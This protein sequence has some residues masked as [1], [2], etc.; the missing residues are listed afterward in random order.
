MT[1]IERRADKL[2]QMA[3]V[4]ASP[5]CYGCGATA[6]VAHHIIGRR[7]KSVRHDPA[8]GLAVC[9]SC[10]G[11]IHAGRLDAPEPD[12]LREKARTKYE[13]RT[14][15]ESIERLKKIYTEHRGGRA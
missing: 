5:Q 6:I 15:P 12:G 1:N 2:F 3:V 13:P 7:F 4:A 8:N 14:L 10:H 9:H 11:D